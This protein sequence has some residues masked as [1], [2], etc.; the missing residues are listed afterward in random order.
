MVVNR[1]PYSEAG[2]ILN[3]VGGVRI[4][5]TLTREEVKA[6]LIKNLPN[7]QKITFNINIKSSNNLLVANNSIF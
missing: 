5:D 4:L 2:K 6:I 7:S 3:E 1:Y